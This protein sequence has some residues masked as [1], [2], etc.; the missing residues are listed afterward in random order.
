M[1][2]SIGWIVYVIFENR[3]YNRVQRQILNTLNQDNDE[4]LHRI[5]NL[6]IAQCAS[7]IISGN[8]TLSKM[9]QCPAIPPPN[10]ATGVAA[11]QVSPSS[12]VHQ[13]QT[14]PMMQN[15][16]G[17]GVQ[18]GGMMVTTP[19]NHPMPPMPNYGFFGNGPLGLS[20]Q[21]Q[22]PMQQQMNQ[23]MIPV[24]FR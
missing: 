10:N 7:P 15:I 22:N 11:G 4:L 21:F 5:R 19:S 12:P 20:E 1:L 2:L 14:R 17:F 13:L 8:S 23:P 6:E 18:V 9:L 16:P 3:K 24:P